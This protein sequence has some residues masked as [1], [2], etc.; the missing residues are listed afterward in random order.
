[1]SHE[2]VKFLGG[3]GGVIMSP[4]P[5]K[6]LGIIMRPEHIS[7]SYLAQFTWGVDLHRT[8]PRL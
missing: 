1:M 2:L 5:V 7:G 3:G 8:C 6:F 4:E